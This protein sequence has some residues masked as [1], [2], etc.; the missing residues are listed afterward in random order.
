M[1]V[2]IGYLFILDFGMD[3]AK[4]DFI[5]TR[6]KKKLSREAHNMN[7]P[8]RRKYKRLST[9]LDLSCRKVGSIQE[10]FHTGRTVNVSPGGLYFETVATTFKPGNLLPGNLLRV[11]LSIPP[12]MGL[13][14]VGGRIS[15]FARVLRT[16]NIDDS[17]LSAKYGVALEFCQSPKL[18]T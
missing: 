6:N 15:G 16:C 13:L 1:K 9:K 3:F 18:S 12:T 4:F 2:K 11:E 8:E 7:G 5:G 17:L 10:E 14:E